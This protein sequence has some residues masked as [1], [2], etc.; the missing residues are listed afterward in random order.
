MTSVPLSSSYCRDPLLPPS[1]WSS[2]SPHLTECLSETA[3]VL[4]PA[5]LLLLAAPLLPPRQP[6]PRTSLLHRLRQL[7]LLLLL[8]STLAELLLLLLHLPAPPVLQVSALLRLGTFLLATLLYHRLSPTSI[9][10]F[11]F[12][13]L[14]ASCSLVRLLGATSR[15][16]LPLPDQLGLATEL[17][18]LLLLLLSSCLAEPDDAAL[19][20]DDSGHQGTPE[21]RCRPTLAQVAASA[22][23]L[24]LFSWATPLTVA[25]W[26]GAL[27]S[28]DMWALA[29]RNTWVGVGTSPRYDAVVAAWRG[30]WAAEQARQGDT[31][32]LLRMLFR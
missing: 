29:R 14:A 1:L 17:P 15:G 19:L 24:L 28:R 2:P 9:P 18:L 12:W 25:G 32:S 10:L 31:V 5:L 6:K 20:P 21:V 11:L 13:L 26:R 3:P 22:P 30:H 7:L 8:L 4:L 16:P 27:A 23:S